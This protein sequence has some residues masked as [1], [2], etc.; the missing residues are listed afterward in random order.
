MIESLIEFKKR[1][2]KVSEHRKHQIRN[3]FG[4]YDGYKYYRKNKPVDKKYILTESQYFSIT[5]FINN[6]LA[7]ELSKGNEIKLPHKMGTIEIRKYEKSIKL[8][9]QGRVIT[10]LPIDW[11]RTLKLWYEDSEA[12]NKKTLLKID[13]KEMFKIMYN[14]EQA[15]YNNQSFYDITFNKELRLKLKR[16]IKQGIVDALLI[17][18]RKKDGNGI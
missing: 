9:D 3:S 17:G 13:E 6:L 5:R 4:I 12:F 1:I 14:K 11:D 15:N 18:K 8:D 16:N 2:R 7:N 10:N